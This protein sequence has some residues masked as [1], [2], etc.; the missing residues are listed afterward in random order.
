M[1][2]MYVASG[3]AATFTTGDVFELFAP[4]TAV[5]IIHSLWVHQ[6][7]DETDD[8]GVLIL[9]RGVTTGSGGA[10]ITAQP[11]DPGGAAFGGTIEEANSTGATGGTDLYNWKWSALAGFEK[12]WLPETR[13]VLA[14]SQGMVLDMDA[15]ITSTTLE[16][17]VEFEE[18]GT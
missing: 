5:V 10:S 11:L 13:L 8:T 4:S 3:D 15:T 18:I 17:G 2:K 7:T 9:R 16:W 12:V 6:S 14:P 1:G